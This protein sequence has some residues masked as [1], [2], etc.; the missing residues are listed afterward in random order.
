VAGDINGIPRVDP[1]GGQ[2]A[3]WQ[4]ALLA[5]VATKPGAVVHRTLAAR[6]DA[7]LMRATRGRLSLAVGAIPLVV[8][9]STGARSG[10]RRETPLVYFTDGD[11]VVLMASSYGREHH[12]GWYYN[13][14][15]HPACELRVG[16]RGG[17]FVARPVEGPER[18]RLFALAADHYRGYDNY[19]ERT[20]GVRTIPVLRLTP[21][22]GA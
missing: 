22:A 21:A 15:A 20:D 8:L 9:T 10:R 5:A 16:P 14:V 17:A 19:A 6:L 13:L 7:P 18:D 11:D 4:R 3:R 2:R 12:P 1:R